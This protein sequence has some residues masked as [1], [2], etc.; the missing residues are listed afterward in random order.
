M[1]TAVSNH[2]YMFS[3]EKRAK[4]IIADVIFKII[5]KMSDMYIVC[6]LSS[7]FLFSQAFGST[8]KKYKWRERKGEKKKKKKKKKKKGAQGVQQLFKKKIK[9]P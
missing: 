1:K 2:K 5:M 4:Q 8:H 6:T 7:Y 3:P 9:F